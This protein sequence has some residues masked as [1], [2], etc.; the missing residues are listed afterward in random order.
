MNTTTDRRIIRTKRAIYNAFLALIQERE[1]EK[2]TVKELAERADINR[3]TFYV[4]YTGLDDLA[5]QIE[6]ELFEHCSPLLRSINVMSR[7]FDVYGFFEA[8]ADMI[9]NNMTVLQLLY[10]SGRLSSLLER[11]KMLLVE[12]FQKQLGDEVADNKTLQLY[13]EF[14][15]AGFLSMFTEWIVAPRITLAEFTE[16][17]A[18]ITLSSFRAIQN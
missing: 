17:L 1:F 13:L 16:V 3:K 6:E 14:M 2:I 12:S 4:Y 9:E 18:K 5:R 7:D 10:R 15:S 8:L 11:T